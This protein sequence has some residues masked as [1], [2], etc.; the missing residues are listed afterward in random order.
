MSNKVLMVDELIA[1]LAKYKGSKI[2]G[3]WEISH[4]D[5]VVTIKKGAKKPRA[6]K[7]ESILKL[8][9]KIATGDGTEIY[10]FH[11]MCYSFE[12]FCRDYGYTYATNLMR[13]TQAVKR[14]FPSHKEFTRE[15][16]LLVCKYIE[17]FEKQ[18]KTATY[19]SPTWNGLI[20]AM[21]K[22]NMALRASQ[23]RNTQKKLDLVEEEF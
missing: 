10:N 22:V 21:P 20:Y 4:K 18:V 5:G 12:I 3:N 8:K 1:I 6:S 14:V 15:D 9:T 16:V 2:A 17:I 19:L 7:A 13:D 23:N 11:E